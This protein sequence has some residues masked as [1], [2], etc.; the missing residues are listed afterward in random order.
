MQETKKCKNCKGTGFVEQKERK[1]KCY[2]CNGL[3]Y[4]YPDEKGNYY[5]TR[6]VV[7]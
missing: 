6:N 7:G 5:G 2:F 3:G 4:K 1:S